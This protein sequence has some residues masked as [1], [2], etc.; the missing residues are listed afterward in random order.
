MF[1][2]HQT[3]ETM[4]TEKQKKDKAEI[5]ARLKELYKQ[6]KLNAMG[7]WFFSDEPPLLS[8]EGADMKAILK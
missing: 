3:F 8:L 1:E 5:I 7:M 6:G 2:Q 4:K